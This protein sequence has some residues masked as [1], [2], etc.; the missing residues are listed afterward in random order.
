MAEQESI[1]MLVRNHLRQADQAVNAADYDAALHNVEAAIAAARAQEHA[2]SLA[3]AYYG[4]ASVIWTFT[5]DDA[6]AHHYTNLAVQQ[7]K[8][9]TKTDLLARTLVARIKAARGNYEAAV[10]LNEDLLRYYY[11]TN[12]LPGQADIL[13]SLGDIYR[14]QGQF[15]IA[16]ERYLAAL[17]VYQ[18][19]DDPI[20]YAGL[21]MSLGTLH[22][23]MN[24]R[25]QAQRYW[26]E[27]RALA[28]GQ[29]FRH[30][31]LKIDEAMEVLKEA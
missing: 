3:A 5:G 21:L 1:L 20:N 19:Y 7:T 30:V 13:R 14:A 15:S 2:A 24:D 27:A 22:Y 6:Q 12:D 16:Q 4:K 25:A 29:G 28:E 10:V 31:L 26:Q 18:T 23:Q 8:T 17:G 11:E 9:N